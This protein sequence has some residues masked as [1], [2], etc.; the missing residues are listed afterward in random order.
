MCG[1]GPSGPV[2]AL[3]LNGAEA[4]RGGGGEGAG[5]AERK[6]RPEWRAGWAAREGRGGRGSGPAECWAGLGKVV[7]AGFGFELLFFWFSFLFLF[8]FF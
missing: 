6:G 8:F 5:W 1:A 2:R 7:W 3:G 4:G